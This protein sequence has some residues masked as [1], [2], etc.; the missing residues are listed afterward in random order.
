MSG[1]LDYIDIEKNPQDTQRLIFLTEESQRAEG[2]RWL[3]IILTSAKRD[4]IP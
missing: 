4:P 2:R 3:K 1:I